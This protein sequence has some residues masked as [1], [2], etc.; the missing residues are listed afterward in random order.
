[1]QTESS[2]LDKYHCGRPEEVITFIN[3]LQRSLTHIG[4]FNISADGFPLFQ[5][6][7]RKFLSVDLKEI[8]TNDYLPSVRFLY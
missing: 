7:F 1:M 3:H 8:F 6:L 4:F 5:D 2:D